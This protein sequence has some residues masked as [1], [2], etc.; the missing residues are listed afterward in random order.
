MSRIEQAQKAK[1]D[2]I[3][4]LKNKKKLTYGEQTFLNSLKKIEPIDG[5]V[6]LYE[7]NPVNTHKLKMDF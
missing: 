4:K 1:D 7:S 3:N 2:F 5:K 6:Y